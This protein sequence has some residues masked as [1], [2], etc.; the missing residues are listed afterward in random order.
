MRNFFVVFILFMLAVDIQAQSKCN[1]SE[2]MAEAIQ[3]DTTLKNKLEEIEIFTRLQ[4]SN[5][6]QR[7]GNITQIIRI[8]VVFH[9]LYRTADENISSEKIIHQ[10]NALNRDF[11]RKNADSIKTPKAFLPVASDMEIEFYLAKQDPR[12]IST[13][14]IIRKYTPVS[15][16]VSDD[17]MKF[18]KTAGS[19]AWD[20][21]SYL[22]IWVCKM[23]DVMGYSNLP[24]TE[25]TKDGI[26]LSNLH[27]SSNSNIEIKVG[28]TLVHEVGHWLNLRH[29]WGDTYCGDDLVNDTPTQSTF[30]VGCHTEI[31]RT[32]GNTDAGDMYMNYMDFTDD[33][34]MNL[35][36]KGQ[37]QRA[38]SLFEAGGFRYSIL[39]SKAFDEPVVYTSALPDF[40]PKWTEVKLYPNPAV[41]A[42]N[43]NLEYDDRWIGNEIQVIDV[44]GNIIFR[45]LIS[46]TN[47]QIDVARLP[48]GVYFIRSQK[49]TDNLLK[50]FVKL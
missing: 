21:K 14:G 47:Q 33:G 36:T 34:C 40:Y 26:V 49:G 4:N 11:R 9:V 25:S 44:T 43:I 10:L 17:K 48:A 28:R 22:N 20:T 23:L 29:I 3:K 31:R 50:K 12:G 45:K 13:S 35:F 30:T 39:Y 42:I 5:S 41:N 2:Y 38:R 24:G 8:P 27:I 32:C 6:N 1:S 37:K 16:W 19:D 18:N 15:Y 7:I 46:S